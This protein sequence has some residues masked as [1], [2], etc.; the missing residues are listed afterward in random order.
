MGKRLSGMFV[1]GLFLAVV[2][3]ALYGQGGGLTILEPGQPPAML[4]PLVGHAKGEAHGHGGGGGGGGSA[5]D[6]YYHGGIGGVGVETAPRIYLVL[7]GSQW[8][9]NDPSGES[10]ILQNFYSGVGG[11]SWLNSVTQYCQ[12]VS[13]GTRLCN[14]AGS[15][16]GNP[17]G[18]FGGLWADNGAAAPSA[19][20]Q[21]QL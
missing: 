6:L 10:S 20:T 8:N 15:P 21:S 16:A 5:A 2:P 18:I 4:H 19:P 13:F 1:G 3:L 7:W 12:G 9:G 17:S 14:G 11:S